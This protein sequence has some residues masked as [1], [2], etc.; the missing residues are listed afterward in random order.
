MSTQPIETLRCRVN[1]ELRIL[2]LSNK[3]YPRIKAL[4]ESFSRVVNCD[5]TEK[6]YD[7]EN[8][9]NRKQVLKENANERLRM[10]SSIK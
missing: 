5:N 9:T 7:A 1:E 3:T 4:I 6:L 10:S 8:K 2:S